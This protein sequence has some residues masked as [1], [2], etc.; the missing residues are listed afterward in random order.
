MIK[1]EKPTKI[2]GDYNFLV[3]IISIAND[4]PRKPLNKYVGYNFLVMITSIAND[5][6]RKANEANEQTCWFPGYDYIHCKHSNK[7]NQRPY[8][9]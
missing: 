1:E 2:Y 7:K 4:Q 5:Q 6:A 9:L 3:I 8:W